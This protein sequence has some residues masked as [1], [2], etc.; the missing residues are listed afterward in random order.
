MRR[1]L[2]VLAVG[3]LMAAMLVASALPAMADNVKVPGTNGPP[4]TS[5]RGA[6]VIHFSAEGEGTIA[7]NLVFTPSGNVNIHQRGSP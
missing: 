7:G 3:A 2:L 6:E 1:I 4:V 5:G